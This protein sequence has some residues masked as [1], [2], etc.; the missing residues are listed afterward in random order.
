FRLPSARDNRPMR[1]DEWEA[2]VSDTIC[3]SAT[4]NPY[5]IEKAGGAVVEQLIRPT[6]LVDPHVEVRP[7]RGQIK[8]L[9]SEIK[10][11]VARHER[12]LVTTLTKRLAEELATF[13][14]EEG[15]KGTYL[16]SE[17]QTIERVRILRDLRKGVFDVLVGVNLLR[18]GLDLPEVT[19]VAIMDSDKEGFLRSETSIIQTVGRTARNI[20]GG[21]IL[22]AD[23][24]TKSMK[25]AID[26]M[27][28]RRDIQ[29]EYNREHGITPRTIEKEIRS[30][31]EEEIAARG[32]AAESA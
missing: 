15:I 19:L 29:L 28:R 21:V 2:T 4:P 8:D 12:V 20:N 5:E 6:G 18:E 16:H 31:I 9:M 27:A 1:F 14:R 7:A 17:V 32:I 25:R 10:K 24:V 3:M 22:Y 23:T 30:G 13:L 11:R 26:E